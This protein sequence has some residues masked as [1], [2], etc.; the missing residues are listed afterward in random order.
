MRS[1]AGRFQPVRPNRSNG[2]ETGPAERIPQSSNLAGKR[3]F[4]GPWPPGRQSV[5]GRDRSSVAFSQ[6]SLAGSVFQ[7]TWVISALR[8]PISRFLAPQRTARRRGVFPGRVSDSLK[9]SS[10]RLQSRLK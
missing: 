6:S 8:G 1:F 7:P 2:T 5:P 4:P 3:A 9:T 10:G